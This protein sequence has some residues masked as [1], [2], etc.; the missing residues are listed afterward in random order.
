MAIMLKTLINLTEFH[1][2]NL[3]EFFKQSI[4]KKQSIRLLALHGKQI[5]YQF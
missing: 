3:A 1:R 5:K 2:K 4:G